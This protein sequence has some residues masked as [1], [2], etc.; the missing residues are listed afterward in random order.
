M[1]PSGIDPLPRRRCRQRSRNSTWN[2]Q[3]GFARHLVKPVNPDEL[4]AAIDELMHA[5]A[6]TGTESGGDRRD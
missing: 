1:R 2:T 4:I 6:A 5:P 3:A